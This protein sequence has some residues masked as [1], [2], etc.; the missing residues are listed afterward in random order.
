MTAPVSRSRSNCLI[1]LLNRSRGNIPRSRAISLNWSNPFAGI[2]VNETL[3]KPSRS[4]MSSTRSVSISDT[5][6]G[7]IKSGKFVAISRALFIIVAPQDDGA[8]HHQAD[9]VTDDLFQVRLHLKL[10]LDNPL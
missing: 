2:D 4:T 7:A 6:P 8:V 5:L 9:R 10:S 1:A 3:V